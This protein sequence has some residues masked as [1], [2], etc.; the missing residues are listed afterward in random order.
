MEWAPG[1]W[2]RIPEKGLE[3]VQTN[4]ARNAEAQ[5]NWIRNIMNT[6]TKNT[7]LMNNFTK[8]QFIKAKNKTNSARSRYNYFV[9]GENL[10][11]KCC[12]ST[13]I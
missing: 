8:I 13:V 7:I 3:N 6:N 2:G 9:L 5:M 12:K 10:P 4:T 1:E 11:H